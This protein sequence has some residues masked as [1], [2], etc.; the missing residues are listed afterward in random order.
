MMQRRGVFQHMQ[1]GEVARGSE[2]GR[3]QPVDADLLAGGER[4]RAHQLLEVGVEPGPGHQ[5]RRGSG[6]DLFGEFRE[7]AM[8]FCGENALLDA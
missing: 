1:G 4:I 5:A 3:F 6:A 8:I 7:A 2:S